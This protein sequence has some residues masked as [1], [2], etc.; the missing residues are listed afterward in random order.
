MHTTV[1]SAA[2]ASLMRA[3]QTV[4]LRALE[5]L[6]YQYGVL[7]K[8][9]SD[10]V[11][12]SWPLTPTPWNVSCAT[13]CAHTTPNT[14]QRQTSCPELDISQ[15]A[16][17]EAQFGALLGGGNKV[18]IASYCFSIYS[19]WV[20]DTPTCRGRDISRGCYASP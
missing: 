20:Y 9:L 16:M 10:G 8:A 7:G 19:Q 3:N 2:L 15:L 11:R 17:L 13:Q 1:C 4:L 12:F 6:C 18:C 5:C 14:P